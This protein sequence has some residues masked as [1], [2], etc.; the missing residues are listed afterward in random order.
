MFVTGRVSKFGSCGICIGIPVAVKKRLGIKYED[1]FVMF[2][3]DKKSKKQRMLI[4]FNPPED[5]DG[6]ASKQIER[7]LKR[8][9]GVL[10]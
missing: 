6:R 10:V 2:L 5:L 7:E 1:S 8:E 9:L 4:I 3:D